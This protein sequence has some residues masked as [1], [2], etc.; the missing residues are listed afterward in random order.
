MH[1][2]V[3]GESFS[4]GSCPPPHKS[5]KNMFAKAEIQP[6]TEWNDVL[7]SSFVTHTGPVSL[8]PVLLHTNVW[9]MSTS[10]QIL[11]ETFPFYILF[12]FKDH[13]GDLWR[14]F[15]VYIYSKLERSVMQLVIF[16]RISSLNQAFSP[17]WTKNKD[18]SWDVRI[19]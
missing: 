6:L 14:K 8:L 15:S 17:A 11:A 7:H 13:S 5:T 2:S 9:V 3:K 4:A 19:I 12:I 10:A 18:F 16:P 1:R